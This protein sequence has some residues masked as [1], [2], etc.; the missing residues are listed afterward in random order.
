MMHGREKSDSSILVKTSGNKPA[1]AGADL[2]ERRE[3]AKG[4]VQRL[5]VFVYRVRSPHRYRQAS[6]IKG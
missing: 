6:R 3:E 5:N 2:T 4:N 1:L